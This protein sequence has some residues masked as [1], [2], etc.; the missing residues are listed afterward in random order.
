MVTNA[1]V[2]SCRGFDCSL[3]VGFGDSAADRTTIWSRK[4]EVISQRADK[5]LAFLR[6][7]VPRRAAV[8][9]PRLATSKL[10]AAGGTDLLAIGWPRLTLRNSWQFAPPANHRQR[11]KRYSRG[12][13]VKASINSE[14]AAYRIRLPPMTRLLLHTADLLPGSS[15]GPLVNHRGEIV[16]INTR[17]LRSSA[18]RYHYRYCACAPMRKPAEECVH[19]AISSLEVV[20]ELER[21]LLAGRRS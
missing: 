13:L 20:R 15:G 6:V 17:I 11:A 19:V 9:V 14:L 1:H 4:A 8:T 7:R 16:G 18:K 10:D 21:L 12:T 5:D 2:I 3:K